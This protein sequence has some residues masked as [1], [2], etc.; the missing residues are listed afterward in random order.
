MEEAR[1]LFEE[2]EADGFGRKGGRARR[3][4]SKAAVFNFR[5]EAFKLTKEAAAIV[6]RVASAYPPAE[7]DHIFEDGLRR[8]K[9]LV[10]GGRRFWISGIEFSVAELAFIERRRGEGGDVV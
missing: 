7:R 4:P 10:G 6:S 9:A 2:L 3:Q 8:Y 5:G 1:L